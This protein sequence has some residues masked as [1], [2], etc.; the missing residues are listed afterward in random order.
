MRDREA[1]RHPWDPPSDLPASLA[2]AT[3]GSEVVVER[4]LLDL[5]RTNCYDLGISV[6]DRLR[7]EERTRGEIVV[8][9]RASH[10]IRL[11]SPYAFY[12]QVGEAYSE[13]PRDGQF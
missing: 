7:V 1:T 6:G 10:V 5:V 4:I 9:N 8:R 2:V 3:T 11:A 13:A 12:V